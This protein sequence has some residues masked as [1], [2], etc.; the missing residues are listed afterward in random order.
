MTATPPPPPTIEGSISTNADGVFELDNKMIEFSLPVAKIGPLRLPCSGGG[1]FRL[2]PSLLFNTLFRQ[3]LYRQGTI[4]LYLHSWEFDPDQ[5]RAKNAGL[6]N[7]FRHYTGLSKT[8]P[9]LRTLIKM[10]KSDGVQFKTMGSYAQS[11]GGHPLSPLEPTG[12]APPAPAAAH[13]CRP[14]SIARESPN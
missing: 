6:L 4:S 9:R 10:L 2:Y 5:P 7:S 12:S 14:L 8:L 13:V 11:L 1:Y 3:I